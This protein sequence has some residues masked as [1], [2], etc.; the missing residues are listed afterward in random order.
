MS[1][2]VIIRQELG[3]REFIVDFEP[4]RMRQ[5]EGGGYSEKQ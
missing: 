2:T 3:L 4:K 5:K 1:N